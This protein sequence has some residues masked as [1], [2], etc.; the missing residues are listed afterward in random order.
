MLQGW[1]DERFI[2]F[3]F[4]AGLCNRR[5]ELQNMV[6]LARALNRTLV[7]IVL[8]FM[9]VAVA[10]VVIA[11]ASTIATCSAIAVMRYNTS[12]SCLPSRRSVTLLTCMTSR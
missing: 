12:R 7:M 5:I 6:A 8:I 3:R 4:W 1:G 10:L 2:V 11:F 9:T